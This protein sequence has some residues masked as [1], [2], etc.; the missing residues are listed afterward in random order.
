MSDEGSHSHIK[1]ASDGPVRFSATA[2]AW[3][4]QHLMRKKSAS[5]PLRSTAMMKEAMWEPPELSPFVDLFYRAMDDRKLLGPLY[6]G[7]RNTIPPARFLGTKPPVPP[8][9]E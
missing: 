9:S 1:E 2:S 5:E 4:F 3:E 7:L 8:P 6:S